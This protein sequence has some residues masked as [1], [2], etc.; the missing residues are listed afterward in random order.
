MTKYKNEK[1]VTKEFMVFNKIR[2]KGK[3]VSAWPRGGRG[4]EGGRGR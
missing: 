3:I 1:Q 2:A 4:G